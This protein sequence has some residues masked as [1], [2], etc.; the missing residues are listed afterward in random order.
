MLLV[1]RGSQLYAARSRL[2]ALG[3]QCG[4]FNAVVKGVAVEVHEHIAQGVAQMVVHANVLVVHHT[5]GRLFAQLLSQGRQRLNHGVD[6]LVDGLSANHG[7]C[8][9]GVVNGLGHGLRVLAVVGFQEGQGAVDFFAVD[10]HVGVDRAFAASRFATQ[11]VFADLSVAVDGFRHQVQLMIEALVGPSHVWR[12]AQVVVSLLT[13]VHHVGQAH[14]AVGAGIALDGVHVAEQQAD[15]FSAQGGGG[16]L[17]TL[18]QQLL[19]FFHKVQG[20]DDELAE[21]VGRHG[22]NFAN[23]R[24]LAFLSF[25]GFGQ[26]A[27]FGHIAHAQH[28]ALAN[29]VLI[30][31][32]RPRQLQNFHTSVG[33]GFVDFAGQ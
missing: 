5:H 25:G 22:Q 18:F 24:Q 7:Q 17:A 29:V 30:G 32:G 11:L 16:L 28:Q 2:V 3:A 8:G 14:Q 19:V 13:L 15:D 31:N 26:S 12:L 4:A 27:H 33:H 20:V 9:A 6:H 1:Q 21:L 10:R 23:L